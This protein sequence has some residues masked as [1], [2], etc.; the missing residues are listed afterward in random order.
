MYFSN[1]TAGGLGLRPLT[2]SFKPVLIYSNDAQDRGQTPMGRA[3][4]Y[5]LEVKPSALAYSSQLDAFIVGTYELIE[6]KEAEE[7]LKADLRGFLTGA[8][9]SDLQCSKINSR[10][11]S[12]YYFVNTNSIYGYRQFD[13][14]I[15][16]SG[17][18]FDI[19][20]VLEDGI[21]N[22]IYV[23]H[24]NG[25]V[26]RY[27]IVI[28]KIQPIGDPIMVVE[29]TSILLT[30]IDTFREPP[31]HHSPTGTMVV[32]GDSKGNITSLTFARDGQQFDLAKVN[33]CQDAIWQVR[34]LPL[35]LKDP[36]DRQSEFSSPLLGKGRLVLV[37]AENSSWYI[38]EFKGGDQLVQLY[39]NDDFKAGI[40]SICN[41]LPAKRM[42][43]KS[44]N[45]R[46]HLVFIGSY[47]ETIKEYVIERKIC[48]DGSELDVRLLGSIKLPGAGIWRINLVS[49]HDFK[50][51]VEEG[52][53]K[54]V[55]DE[56]N[57]ATMYAK[58]SK[59][60]IPVD[61]DVDLS[62]RCS[63]DLDFD[64]PP[65]DKGAIVT[66]LDIPTICKE[67]GDKTEDNT[68]GT[69]NAPLYYGYIR[70][71]INSNSCFT[72]FNNRLCIFVEPDSAF[73]KE[74]WPYT[75]ARFQ[76]K[77]MLSRFLS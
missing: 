57:V 7:R 45:R 65:F 1:T 62:L 39:K 14:H 19:S 35:W 33:V 47:D 2:K 74:D 44:V 55:Y 27:K 6:T 29:D 40:T 43:N 10:F 28:D 20:L 13:H 61:V 41:R 34:F 17:G 75:K 54:L 22:Q 59:I 16:E 50:T 12:L 70:S 32:V 69:R 63:D 42:Y 30:C 60:Q 53:D 68:E 37:G 8:L 58:P 73:S 52:N 38:Y 46:A 76:P 66:Q 9:D 67:S 64:F 15:C 36:F 49:W 71:N 51:F 23:A 48:D 31:N 11:G 21:K 72:D 24:S 18:V 4:A 3:Y 26:G 25:S 5:E 77:G 56:L